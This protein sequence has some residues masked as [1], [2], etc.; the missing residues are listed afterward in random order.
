[1][2]YL[3]KLRY[4]PGDPLQEIRKDDV[5]RIARQSG[6][7]LGISVEEI[8]AEEIPGGYEKTLDKSLEEITQTVITLEGAEE[9]SLREGLR[10]VITRYRAP[11]TVYAL[12]GSNPEGMAIAGETIEEMDGWW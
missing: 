7:G 12:W 1:M 8:G 11:R 5:A 3:V 6:L 10:E 9:P 4:Y 2:R